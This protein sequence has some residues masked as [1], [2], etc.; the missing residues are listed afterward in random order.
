MRKY[1]RAIL[2][3]AAA[4]LLLPLTTAAHNFK[5][6]DIAIHRPWARAT[7]GQAPN[8]AAY[9]TLINGGDRADF[10]IG[11]AGAAAK[12]IELHAHAMQDGVMQMRGV[13]EIRIAPGVPT[14]LE[15]G[16]LHL[17]LIGL[18]APLKEGSSFPVILTFKEGGAIRIAVKV[19]GAGA[20]TPH[21]M[22]PHGI[23]Q[24]QSN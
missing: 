24:G 16:G 14:L 6:G 5:I 17:M 19:E 12:R 2:A 4:I 18:K 20:M 21:G 15:P 10:L 23:T 1:S 22:T 8:G 13:K 11:A 3:L 9:M 7:A